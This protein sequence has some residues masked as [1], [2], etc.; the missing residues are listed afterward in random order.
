MTI[1][2]KWL[3]PFGMPFVLLM[4]FR[5]MWLAAS[6]IWEVSYE[7]AQLL[8][9]VSSVLGFTAGGFAATGMDSDNWTVKIWG[10]K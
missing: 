5:L 7:A 3:L 1:D 9:A 4:F 2:L 8:A 10:K 6:G